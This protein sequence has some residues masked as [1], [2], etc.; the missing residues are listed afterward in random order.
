MRTFQEYYDRFLAKEQDWLKKQ[1]REW[2]KPGNERYLGIR[3]TYPETTKFLSIDEK[4]DSS[5][6]QNHTNVKNSEWSILFHML[7][8]ALVDWCREKGATWKNLW[9][10]SFLIKR[11]GETVTLGSKVKS[12]E[13]DHWEYETDPER[14]ECFKG[15]DEYFKDMLFWFFDNHKGDVPLDWN[16]FGFGLDDLADSVK[17]GEW[18]PASDGDI[19][20]GHINPETEEYVE[21]VECM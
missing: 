10:Y 11:E 2:W 20:L 5:L 9:S 12:Y 3:G 18:V 8:Q 1:D 15:L 21:Y 13:G 16:W 7:G 6:F 19:N 4:N 17:F 14:L